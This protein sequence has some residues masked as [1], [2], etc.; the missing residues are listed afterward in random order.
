MLRQATVL[1]D[2]GIFL[3]NEGDVLNGEQDYDLILNSTGAVGK[4]CINELS[5]KMNTMKLSKSRRASFSSLA[6]NK[7]EQIRVGFREKIAKAYSKWN[8]A[9]VRNSKSRELNEGKESFVHPT[10][11]SQAA[12]ET[13]TTAP[14]SNRSRKK[15]QPTNLVS[16]DWKS[17]FESFESKLKK[18][19]NLESEKTGFVIDS[20]QLQQQQIDT[21]DVQD[22]LSLVTKG[23]RV[24]QLKNFPANIG[25]KSLILQVCGGPLE[26]IVVHKGQQLDINNCRSIEF[27]FFKSEDA[28]AFFKYSLT[29]MFLINGS[30]YAAEW[31]LP[32][33]S[34]AYGVYHEEVDD[35]IFEEFTKNNARRTLILKKII[36]KSSSSKKKSTSRHYPSP[37]SHLSE[38]DL[39]DIIQEFSKFGEIFEISPVVS[40][41]LCIAIHFFN[42]KSAISAKREFE[43][44]ASE[45]HA[46]YTDWLIWYGKDPV[47]RLCFQC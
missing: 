44:D 35:L 20:L 31:S 26:K 28:E 39:D 6:D 17:I 7:D 46:K 15:A 13:S 14:T 10:L 11:N 32:H 42:V 47:D 23:R 4:K 25:L 36:K 1:K 30:H 37:K 33:S 9:T 18:D 40:R 5:Q 2:E 19:D 43:D 34:Y 22:D 24:V 21:A 8:D 16:N 29:G 45:L 41:K 38:I 27:W 3:V 12:P